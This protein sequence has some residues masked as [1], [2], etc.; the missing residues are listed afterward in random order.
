M[1]A[2]RDMESMNL[3]EIDW[4]GIA[5]QSCCFSCLLVP[6]IADALKEQ[7]RKD[8]GLPV[9][10]IDRATSEDVGTLPEAGF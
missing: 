9:G 8:I 7:Q 4:I 1:T 6:H 2:L 5:E 3:G 10:P